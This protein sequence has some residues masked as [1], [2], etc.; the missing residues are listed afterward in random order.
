MVAAACGSDTGNNA[1]TTAGPNETVDTTGTTAAPSGTSDT[2]ATSELPGKGF[3]LAYSSGGTIEFYTCAEKAVRSRAEELGFDLVVA[4]SGD[5]PE[6]ELANAEDLLTQKP[7]LYM[8][9]AVNADSAQGVIDKATAAGTPVMVVSNLVAQPP[10]VVGGVVFDTSGIGKM[11]G[12]WVAKDINAGNKDNV[13]IAIIE[14]VGIGADMFTAGFKE[15]LAAATKAYD[16]AFVQPA[17]WNRATAQSVAENMIQANPDLDYV[18]VHNEDMALG[19]LES[20]R[21]AGK[22]DQVKVV[23]QGGTTPGLDAI[24]SGEIDFMV[25]NTPADLGRLTV[26]AALA[27][28]ANGEIVPPIQ[29]VPVVGITKDNVDQAPSYCSAN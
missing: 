4:N 19:V 13:K 3:K 8:L 28:L 27:F 29:T 15:G 1:A 20:L 16:I 11:D 21:A 6:T 14:G 25:S 23:T 17:F 12:E 2:T 9:F 26:D 24:R 22:L 5:N 7:D 10:A 18:F